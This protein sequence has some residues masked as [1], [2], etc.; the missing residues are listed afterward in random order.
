MTAAQLQMRVIIPPVCPYCEEDAEL[1]DKGFVY[2][3]HHD[4][5]IWICKPCRAWVPVHRNSPVHAPLGRLANR[6]L[7]AKRVK[8]SFYF[9]RVWQL[10]AKQYGWSA[11][12]AR[13][14][15]YAWLAREMCIPHQDCNLYAFDEAATQVVIDICSAVGVKKDV[16]A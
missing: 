6:D 2:K 13:Q 14:A 10:M 9:D 11:N 16:A 7:R 1:T 12:K 5:L 4:G 8:A 3:A 15:A